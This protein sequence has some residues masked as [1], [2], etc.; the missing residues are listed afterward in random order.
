MVRPKGRGD[1][2]TAEHVEL[3]RQMASEKLP[4]SLICRKLARTERAIEQR[5]RALGLTLKKPGQKRLRLS[6]AENIGQFP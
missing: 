4:V 1:A 6:C 3:L 5:A 2:W